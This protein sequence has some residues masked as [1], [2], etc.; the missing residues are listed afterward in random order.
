[1]VGNRD[2]AGW[3]KEQLPFRPDSDRF[4]GEEA[5][6]SKQSLAPF[7]Q[8]I[9][10]WNMNGTNLGWEVRNSQDSDDLPKRKAGQQ[11]FFR[12]GTQV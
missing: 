10:G 4:L 12:G 5:P 9:F 1:M 8:G 3:R 6:D 2:W 11:L 7:V